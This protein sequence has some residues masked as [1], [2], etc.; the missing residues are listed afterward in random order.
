[1]NGKKWIFEGFMA[2]SVN[3][4]AWFILNVNLINNIMQIIVA[5]VT[6]GYLAYQWQKSINDK[7]KK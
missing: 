4:G 6:V 2:L 1:M 5:I 7:K 3:I